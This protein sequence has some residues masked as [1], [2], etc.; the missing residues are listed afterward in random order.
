M[1]VVNQVEKRVKVD[2]WS[3]VQYQILTHCFLLDIPISKAELNCLTELAM[4]GEQELGAFCNKIHKK[5]IFKSSQSV[6]N[7]LIKSEK[8]G[9]VQKEGKNK[10]KIFIDPSLKVQTQ[11]N[12]L[13]DFKLLNIETA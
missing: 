1:A 6:R 2:K 7:V 12:I 4:D 8:L 9:L 10:K 11:G 5:G 3:V 13:L